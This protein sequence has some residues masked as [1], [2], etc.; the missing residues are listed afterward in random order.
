MCRGPKATNGMSSGTS[1]RGALAGLATVVVVGIGAGCLGGDAPD[2][3][4]RN[5]SETSRTLRVEVVRGRGE[6]VHTGEYELA[7]DEQATEKE[8]YDRIGTYVVTVSASVVA[9]STEN[10]TTDAE[11]E[12]EATTGEET[13]TD[14]IDVDEPDATLTHVTVRDDGVSIG[15]IAP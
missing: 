9:S 5:F 2:L 4:V 3:R 7:P 11:T 12:E 6:T 10:A 15:R 14:E 13:T 8:V 1:R